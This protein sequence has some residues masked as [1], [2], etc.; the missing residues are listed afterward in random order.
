VALWATRL[1]VPVAVRVARRVVTLSEFSRSQ[2]VKYVRVTP[3]AIQ[4]IYPAV[5]E[6]FRR[7]MPKEERE[8]RLAGL[9]VNGPYL[10]CVANTYPHKNVHALVDAFAVLAREWPGRLVLVGGEGRGEALV[11]ERLRASGVAE[12]VIRL[13][14]LDR[15][16]LV[17]LYQGAACFAFPSLYEGFGLPVLE[18]MAA[19]TPVVAVGGGAVAEIGGD[20]ILY[21]DGTP[22]AL[23][24]DLRRVLAL[25][26]AA[27]RETIAK[28]R[29][30]AALF[31]WERC[32]DELVACFRWASA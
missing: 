10:L 21:G 7:G 22:D 24:R 32:A 1:L 6:I 9:A 14:R 25:D 23:V 27:R 17:A 29:Q 31:T 18:A 28:A 5:D 4:V 30:R 12:R 11:D 26:D 16:D 15:A 13:R 3:E 20:G 19:G 8:R 2:I